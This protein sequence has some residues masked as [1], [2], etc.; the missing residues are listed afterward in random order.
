ML[1]RVHRTASRKQKELDARLRRREASARRDHRR[2]GR[3]MALFHFQEEAAGAIFWHAGGAA[4]FRTVRAYRCRRLEAEGYQELQIPRLVGG[5][6]WERSG[7]RQKFREHMFGAEIEDAGGSALAFKPMNRPGHVQSYRQGLK[8]CRDF[9]LR[10]AEFGA[11]HRYEPSR[12]PTEQAAR[13]ERRSALMVAAKA[14]ELVPGDHAEWRQ[15]VCSADQETDEGNMTAQAGTDAR[16]RR[17]G[18]GPPRRR[19]RRSPP[20]QA[21]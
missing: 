3:E 16:A 9:L 17:A 8:S 15:A 13:R 12:A 1:R 7:H 4:L 6:L 5:A 18:P 20:R 19:P 14:T 11:C 10:M 21:R 2:L